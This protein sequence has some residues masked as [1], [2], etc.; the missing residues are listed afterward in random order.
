MTPLATAAYRDDG[1]FSDGE[2]RI[3]G[4]WARCIPNMYPAVVPDPEAPT[5]EWIAMHA[6]GYHEVIIESPDHESSPATFSQDMISRMIGVYADRYRYYKERGSAYISIFKNW[7]R[8]AGAS[9]SHTH[10]QLIALP[11]LPPLIMRELSAISSMPLCPYCSI[12]RREVCSERFVFSKG[13]WACIAPFYSQSPYEI[14]ILPLKHISD[15]SEL[16]ETMRRDLG[17][18]LKEA[19]LRLSLLLK[20]PPYNYMIFQKDSGYHLNIRIQPVTSKIAGFE[21]NTGMFINP[22]SPEQAASDL[23]SAL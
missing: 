17:S 11:I 21:K 19:L 2:R 16:D 15:L 14:W 4:W 22:V 7:G 20:D 6:N 13:E 10:T 5:R 8:E 1:V 9:L 3:R 23:R 18:A 12:A